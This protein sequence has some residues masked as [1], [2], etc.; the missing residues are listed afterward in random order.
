LQIESFINEENPH[1]SRSITDSSSP[2][3]NLT[4]QVIKKDLAPAE[5]KELFFYDF[6]KC[7]N[8]PAYFPIN[9]FNA[10]IEKA[11]VG[12]KSKIMKRL[13]PSKMR[14]RKGV[15]SDNIVKLGSK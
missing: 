2:L 1:I 4:S 10:I 9:N 14:G 5:N 15:E 7:F 13:K 3:V 11:F 12:S 6:E 8:F